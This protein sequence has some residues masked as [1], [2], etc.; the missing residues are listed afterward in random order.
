LV[1]TQS[2]SH[3]IWLVA[4]PAT[5]LHAPT[6]DIDAVFGAIDHDGDNYVDFDELKTSHS[7]A[8]TRLGYD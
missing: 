5:V 6:K 1:T 8:S 3:I 4:G 2:S 7:M